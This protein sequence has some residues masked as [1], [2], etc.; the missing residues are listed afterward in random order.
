MGRLF[1][2]VQTTNRK[3]PVGMPVLNVA[4]EIKYLQD[5]FSDKMVAKRWRDYMNSQRLVEHIVVCGPDHHRYR[6]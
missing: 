2:V 5:H 3:K 4:G 1:M 6:S